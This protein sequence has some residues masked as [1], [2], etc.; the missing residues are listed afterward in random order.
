MST[1]TM[2]YAVT[3]LTCGHCVN[4]VT[5]ELT[6]LDAVTEVNVELVAEGVSTVTIASAVPVSDDEIRAALDEA[7]DYVLV[8]PAS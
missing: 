6:A 1:S 4:A 2:R 3:G 7:G 5:D 8:G